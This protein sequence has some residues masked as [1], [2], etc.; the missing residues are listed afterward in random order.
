MD[1]FHR[2]AETVDEKRS[3]W[4]EGSERQ[5]GCFWFGLCVSC[6][7]SLAWKQPPR[8][9]YVSSVPS[10]RGLTCVPA[11][12]PFTDTQSD[13]SHLFPLL[14]HR[15]RTQP[16]HSLENWTYK[17][18]FEMCVL[19]LFILWSPATT[20]WTDLKSTSWMRSLPLRKQPS[21]RRNGPAMHR[22]LLECMHVRW[23]RSQLRDQNTDLSKSVI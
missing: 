13:T 16:L 20:V 21:L 18:D 5:H 12:P 22:K 3:R 15:R 9:W 19:Y 14:Q 4:L 10:A 8:R 6:C 11:K 17:L 1:I 2:K 23:G 7:A